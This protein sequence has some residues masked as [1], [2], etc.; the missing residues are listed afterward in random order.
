M[1]FG[2]MKIPAGAF[3]TDCMVVV[4]NAVEGCDGGLSKRVKDRNTTVL[5]AQVRTA[6]AI[7]PNK[8]V[9]IKKFP[10]IKDADR[11]PTM[12]LASMF[13]PSIAEDKLSS[14]AP[15]RTPDSSP[16]VLPY[17]IPIKYTVSTV[18]FGETARM[19]MLPWNKKA[20][21]MIGGNQRYFT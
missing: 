9:Q 19:D 20:K 15:M 3:I 10:D 4:N 5:S 7:V 21:N 13:G 1:F 17:R 11:N 12:P 2:L 18:R 8:G 16:G 6:T 14:S